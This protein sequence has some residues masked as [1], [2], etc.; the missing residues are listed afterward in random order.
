MG[1]RALSATEDE[2]SST[3]KTWSSNLP[4]RDFC[5]TGV[6]RSDSTLTTSAD[7]TKLLKISTA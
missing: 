5:E 1:R 3:L 2:F 6:V 7:E 4:E